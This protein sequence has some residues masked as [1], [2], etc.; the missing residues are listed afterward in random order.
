MGIRLN[1]LFLFLSVFW[2]SASILVLF[3]LFSSSSFV[4]ITLSIKFEANVVDGLEMTFALFIPLPR[5]LSYAALPFYHA[6]KNVEVDMFVLF[7]IRVFV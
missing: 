4:I 6:K 3:V 5:I 2:S 7:P 1:G